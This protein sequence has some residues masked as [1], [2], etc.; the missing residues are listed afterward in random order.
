[1][2]HIYI[3]FFFLIQVV[4]IKGSV[5]VVVV[6]IQVVGASIVK[7]G[8]GMFAV[9]SISVTDANENSWSIKRR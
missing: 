2:V 3:R 8:S 4:G 1:V 7:S 9:Y 6:V 5:V